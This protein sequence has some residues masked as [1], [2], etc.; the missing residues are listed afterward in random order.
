VNGHVENQALRALVVPHPSP[1]TIL[2][3]QLTFAMIATDPEHFESI[4]ATLSFDTDRVTP[5]AYLGS[6]I[7]IVEAMAWWGEGIDWEWLRPY[8]LEYVDDESNL[9]SVHGSIAFLMEMLRSHGDNH[10]FILFPDRANALQETRGFGMVV[11]GTRIIALFPDG[12]AAK[13]GL[14][15]GDVVTMVDGL[16]PAN[17]P[18]IDPGLGYNPAYSWP[19]ES[20]ITVERPGDSTHF[21]VTLAIETFEYYRPPVGHALDNELGYIDIPGY[22][23]PGREVEF[24]QTGI[25]L[26]TSI[27][28]QQSTCG[29]VVDLRL[30]FGGSYSPM[31]SAISPLVGN[32]T[33]VGWLDRAGTTDWISMEDGS[34][35]GT[36]G[37]ISNYL[38]ETGPTV[39][40][41]PNPP[42]AVLT[43]SQTGSAGEVTALAFTG[44]PDTR[45]FGE[46]TA[47]YTT[48]NQSFFLFDG[49]R[50]ALA[51]SAMTDRNGE[52]YLQGILPDEVVEIDWATHGTANDPVILAAQ[53]W[54]ASQPACAGATPVASPVPEG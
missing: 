23:I 50:L 29:W 31:V 25:D 44:R 9:T 32:G 13:A 54:L 21:E 34:I 6:V 45:F 4:T 35:T 47:G 27:D 16:T 12:P 11:G 53:E 38:P 40:N 1:F 37:P 24:S 36:S 15:V 46:R 28:Q 26:L 39:L 20:I 3:R 19:S 30:N 17:L 2:D 49:T 7:D 33:F 41:Q 22:R 42:I 48:A 10:S 52:T 8:L 43:S 18:G 5:S 14:Q 51:T